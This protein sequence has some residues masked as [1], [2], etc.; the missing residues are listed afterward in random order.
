MLAV[1]VKYYS[2][3]HEFTFVDDTLQTGV[4]PGKINRSYT[5]GVYKRVS[6]TIHPAVRCLTSFEPG[7]IYTTFQH[8]LTVVVL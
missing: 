1:Y 8:L 4:I 5:V 2:Y 3:R 6:R 7:E